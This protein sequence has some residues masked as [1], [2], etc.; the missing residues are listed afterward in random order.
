MRRIV[1]IASAV[2]VV[3]SGVVWGAIATGEARGSASDVP[4]VDGSNP[5]SSMPDRV[6]VVDRHT[7][8]PVGTVSKADLMAAPDER[9]ERPTMD[10]LDANGELVGHVVPGFGFVPLAESSAP[11]Y[12]VAKLR[13]QYPTTTVVLRPGEVP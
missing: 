10:V 6:G 2:L 5:Y 13:D 4:T 1:W 12:D 9:G 7:G 3:A 8:K 11:G